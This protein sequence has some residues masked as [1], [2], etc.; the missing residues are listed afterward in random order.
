MGVQSNYVIAK[1][2]Y[3]PSR[4]DELD[5]KKGEKIV[6]LEQSEDAWW[7]GRNEETGHEGWFPSNYVEPV[8]KYF[9]PEKMEISNTVQL[10]ISQQ[11]S[12]SQRFFRKVFRVKNTRFR[13][14]NVAVRKLRNQSLDC[15]V[16]SVA[17]FK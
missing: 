14:R 5:L 1:F 2:N 9:A 8:S 3:D 11:I 4:D 10:V 12:I 7:R 16:Y 13:K 6:V 15:S 17:Y